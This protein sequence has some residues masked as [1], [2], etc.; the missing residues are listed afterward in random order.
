M[1]TWSFAFA[2]AA[3]LLVEGVLLVGAVRSG[4]ET[5]PAELRGDGLLPPSALPSQGMLVVGQIRADGSVEVTQWIRS[6]DAITGLRLSEWSA[7]GAPRPTDLR[8]VAADGTILADEG[9]GEVEPRGVRLDR[10]TSLVRATYVLNGTTDESSTKP[11][12][13]LVPAVSVGLE[14]TPQAGPT[15]VQV[16]APVGGEVLSLA[17]DD[18]RSP[19][20]LLRPCGQPVGTGWQVRLSADA[21]ADRVA[22]LVDLP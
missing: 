7:P 12:R 17:C 13:R 22:A 1:L 14:S 9:S 19:V 15:F 6:F 16:R 21:R 20:D 4:D 2:A 10:P 8:L 3:A 18:A 11:G 5:G